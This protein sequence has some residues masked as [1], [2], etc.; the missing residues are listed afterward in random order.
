MRKPIKPEYEGPVELPNGFLATDTGDTWHLYMPKEFWTPE[1]RGLFK[2]AEEAGIIAWSAEADKYTR[3][4]NTTKAQLAYWC[5][6]ASTYLGLDRKGDTSWIPFEKVFGTPGWRDPSS[7]ETTKGSNP[8][9]A[10]LH[11]LEEGRL[12][13]EA[14]TKPIDDFFNTLNNS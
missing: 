3:G 4:L 8:L 9:K 6:K 1:A 7:G 14:Y 12:G 13:P 2:A 5:E 10:A 11:N